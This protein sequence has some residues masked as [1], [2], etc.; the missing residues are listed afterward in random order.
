M[1]ER[2]KPGSLQAVHLLKCETLSLRRSIRPLP[3]AIN[4]LTR[5]DE[6]FF[7]AETRPLPP[8]P[9]VAYSCSYFRFRL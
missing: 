3:E 4:S 8:S 6:R 2:P 1:L 5:A 9:A 7:R